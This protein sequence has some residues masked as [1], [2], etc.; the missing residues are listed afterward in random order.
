M[1][2]IDNNTK[3]TLKIRN[4]GYQPTSNKVGGINEGYRPKK[5]PIPKPPTTGTNVITPKKD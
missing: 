1:S 5:T 3:S 4:D 2:K